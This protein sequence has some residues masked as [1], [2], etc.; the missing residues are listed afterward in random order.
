MSG[1]ISGSVEAVAA[2]LRRAGCV[3]AE[4]EAR[5]LVDSASSP[6]H[7][8]TMVRRRAEGLP[9][10]HVVG[11]AE[12]CGRRYVVAPGVFVPRRRSQLL[13]ATAIA[14][15]HPGAIVVDLCCGSGALGAAAAAEVGGVELHACDIDPA[16]ARCARENVAVVG[17]HA[18]QGD[19]YDPLPSRLRGRVDVLLTNAPYVP[20]DAIALLPTEAREHEARVALDGGVDGL[21]VHRRVASGASEW[22]APG[23]TLLIETTEE[24]APT[25]FAVF[26]VHGLVARTVHS[27]DLA[28]TVIV[29]TRSGGAGAV[30]R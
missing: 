16:A 2:E 29:A 3:F 12:L 30:S 26:A 23:G 15:A 7:L 24:Q 6:D 4:D 9:L 19:L 8:A 27:A 22:L 14:L 17:G 5:I 28:A 18:Y 21:D 10:E 1:A 20:T 11:W 25:M 13:V